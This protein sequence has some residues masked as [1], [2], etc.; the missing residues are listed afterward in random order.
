MKKIIVVGGD[1]EMKKAIAIAK[2]KASAEEIEFIENID[3]IMISDYLGGN[4]MEITNTYQ[5]API[6]RMYN[7]PLTRAERRAK[8]RKLRKRKR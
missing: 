6:C 3:E 8:E 5:L 7:P 4:V 1:V 2:L